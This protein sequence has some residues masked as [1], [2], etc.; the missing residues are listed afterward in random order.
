MSDFQDQIARLVTTVEVLHDQFKDAKPEGS[1]ANIESYLGIAFVALSSLHREIGKIE[2]E[3]E[4]ENEE[5]L[6]GNN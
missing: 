4:E 2:E 3:N 6:P 5:G 1:W